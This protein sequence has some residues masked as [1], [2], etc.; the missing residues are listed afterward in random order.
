MFFK[1]YLGPILLNSHSYITQTR[2]QGIN[3][4]YLSWK[5]DSFVN[6]IKV[7]GGEK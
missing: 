2:N 6:L 5:E 7:T 3:S 4:I 1:L